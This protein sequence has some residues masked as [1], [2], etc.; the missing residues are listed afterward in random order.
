LPLFPS[1]FSAPLLFAPSLT[2]H[3][4]R[5]SPT[6]LLSSPLLC[7]SAAQP[8]S[9]SRTPQARRRAGSSVSVRPSLH[10]LH[11][12]PHLAISLPRPSNPRPRHP[13]SCCSGPCIARVEAPQRWSPPCLP[14]CSWAPLLGS[15]TSAPVLPLVAFSFVARSSV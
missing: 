6:P 5:C 11:C 1:Y 8:S 2:A 7:F 15:F 13:L 3:C 4:R 9:S 12:P 10:C 14:P